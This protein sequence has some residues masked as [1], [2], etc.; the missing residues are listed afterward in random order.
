MSLPVAN[1]R[2]LRDPNFEKHKW[3]AGHIDRVKILSPQEDYEKRQRR[4]R[5]GKK[6]FSIIRFM[7]HYWGMK[8]TLTQKSVLRG[9]IGDEMFFLSNNPSSL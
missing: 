4:K 5:A 1:L 8:L 7:E 9:T 6:A 2:C 3:H